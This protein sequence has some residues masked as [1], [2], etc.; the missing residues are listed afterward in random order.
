MRYSEVRPSPAR[1]GGH[2]SPT[3]LSGTSG[4]GAGALREAGG[5]SGRG[6]L[7]QRHRGGKL[8]GASGAS[9]DWRGGVRT[10]RGGEDEPGRGQTWVVGARRLGSFTCIPKAGS[11][12]QGKDLIRTQV[13]SLRCP[14]GLEVQGPE[15]R[16]P[17]STGC[18][19]VQRREAA[20]LGQQRWPHR[21]D[22]G[23]RR[24]V[25][26]HETEPG[27]SRAVLTS[28]ARAWPAGRSTPLRKPGGREGLEGR[29]G[30]WS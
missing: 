8:P 25:T 5:H 21:E 16:Q 27:E 12:R 29:E 20:G 17:V 28:D 23:R 10:G 9:G 19:G 11:F 22:P 13:G 3:G 14:C 2:G 18:A 4:P 15:G 7:A 30:S 26:Q 1:A 6:L 24:E